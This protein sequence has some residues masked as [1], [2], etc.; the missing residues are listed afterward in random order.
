MLRSRQVKECGQYLKRR[1]G[2]VSV[3]LFLNCSGSF[4]MSL[5]TLCYI[6]VVFQHHS[7]SKR[8]TLAL[9]SEIDTLPLTP[10]ASKAS[11]NFHR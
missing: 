4:P 7:T 11:F 6:Q 1:E 5:K 9:F 3:E 8:L 2:Q 10:S